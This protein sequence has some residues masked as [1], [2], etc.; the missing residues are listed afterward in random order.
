MTALGQTLALPASVSSA[1]AGMNTESRA[2]TLRDRPVR[3]VMPPSL[4]P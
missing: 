1:T 2:L 3:S 4:L